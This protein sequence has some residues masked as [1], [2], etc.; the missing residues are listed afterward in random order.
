MFFKKMNSKLH[1]FKHLLCARLFYT[2]YNTLL[3]SFH[4][5]NHP[6]GNHP[7][8]QCNYLVFQARTVSLRE[9][10]SLT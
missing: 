2:L 1:S 5:H 3:S 10:N 8:G 7:V 4:P 6:G 9:V